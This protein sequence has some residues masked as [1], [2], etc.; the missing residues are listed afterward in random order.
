MGI[1]SLFNEALAAMSCQRGQVRGRASM[2]AEYH[3]HPSYHENPT[4]HIGVRWGQAAM[5]CR[6]GL[7]RWRASMAAEYKNPPI[8]I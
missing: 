8:L 7:V 4:L 3:C 1:F 6:R 5:S 2:A